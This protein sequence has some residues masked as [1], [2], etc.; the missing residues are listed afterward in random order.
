M[1]KILLCSF[2]ALLL[3]SC[4]GRKQDVNGSDRILSDAELRPI[5]DSLGEVYGGKISLAD[6]VKAATVGDV[7]AL[8]EYLEQNEK[9]QSPK[10]QAR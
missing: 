1:K 5:L 10:K 4:G 8:I 6:S 3:V 9:P 7:E 2:A